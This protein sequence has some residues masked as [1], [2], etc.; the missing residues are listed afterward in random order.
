MDDSAAYA[1][2]AANRISRVCRC[3]DS[4]ARIGSIIGDWGARERRLVCE[5][6]D[7]RNQGELPERRNLFCY[8]KRVLVSSRGHSKTLSGDL[9]ESDHRVRVDLAISS[10]SANSCANNGNQRPKKAQG[11][12]DIDM[13]GLPV[14]ALPYGRVPGSC[15]SS[16]NISAHAPDAPSWRRERGRPP[17]VNFVPWV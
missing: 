8:F 7:E 5:V 13:F 2:T 3:N 6:C 16:A 14:P 1:R 9:L 12:A 11:A 15:L 4:P 17:D 10:L